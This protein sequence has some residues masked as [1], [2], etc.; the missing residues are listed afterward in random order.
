MPWAIIMLAGCF[1]GFGVLARFFAANPRQPRFFTGELVDDL[2]YWALATIFF[3]DLS[4]MMLGAGV[5]AAFG[6]R[7]PHVLAMINGG[8]GI[9]PRLPLFAQVVI[10]LIATDVI[11]YWQHR[12]FHGRTLWPFHA[13]HH[14]AEQVDW[15]TAF[16]FHPVNYIPYVAGT[17]A[18]V[19]LGGFSPEV[20]VVIAPLN[21][22]FAAMVH[23][24][25]NWTFGPL[26]YVIASPVF[27]RWHHVRDPAIHNMNFA[28]TFPVL[29]LVFGTFYMPRGVMPQDYGA[30]GTP[31][32][33][34]AQMIYPFQAIAR[35]IGGPRPEAVAGG[36]G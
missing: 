19:R 23:S 13:I 16:R 26:R 36:A 3:S 24:N 9:A 29:D 35:R 8:Y 11:Q 2:L 25:L 12:W 32:H 5:S 18:I 20:F 6:A 7:A 28:P 27:H 10:V 33:F 34:L 30:E 1:V 4:A 22:V 31:H 15:S 21:F 14:S 17:A